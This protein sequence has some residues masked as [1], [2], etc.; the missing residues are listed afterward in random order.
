[1][2]PTRLPPLG[3]RIPI[4]AETFVE[5]LSGKLEIHPISVYWLLKEGRETDGW[6]CP[7]EEKRLMEDRLTVLVLRLL[8]HRWPRQVEAGEPVPA[9]ADRDGIIPLTPGCGEPTLADRVEDVGPRD[10]EVPRRDSS[11][12]QARIRRGRR[13][14]LRRLARRLVLRAA[15]LA[16][17]QAP[18][19]LADPEPPPGRHRRGPT[20]AWRPP[21]PAGVRVPGLLPQTRRRPARQAPHPLRRPPAYPVRDRA[22]DPGGGRESHCRPGRPQGPSLQCHRRTPRVRREARLA[23]S[24]IE[25]FACPQAWRPD[26]RD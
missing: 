11:G 19:R 20:T 25:G 2:R 13:P 4:P 9:W 6:R 15:H 14:V 22:A 16:V 17:P 10:G 23:Q 5:E 21:C 7:P 26:R 3:A 18:D 24:P 1:M 8:G 12:P